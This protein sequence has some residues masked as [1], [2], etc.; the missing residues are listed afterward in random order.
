MALESV[1]MLNV[2]CLNNK[3]IGGDRKVFNDLANGAKD[4]LNIIKDNPDIVFQLSLF[5]SDIIKRILNKEQLTEIKTI[6]QDN[7]LNFLSAFDYYQSMDIPSIP[8]LND[9]CSYAVRYLGFSEFLNPWFEKLFD[10]C[11]KCPEYMRT[12]IVYNFIVKYLV[13]TGSAKLGI[14]CPVSII[15]DFRYDQKLKDIFASGSYNYSLNTININKDLINLRQE[16]D[17]SKLGY[18]VHVVFH[19]LKHAKQWYE[20][21]KGSVSNEIYD[22]IRRLLFDTYLMNGNGYTEYRNNYYYDEIEIGANLA[23]WSNTYRF[24]R[25][26]DLLTKNSKN[27]ILNRIRNQRLKNLIRVKKVDD[28][29]YIPA[30]IYNIDHLNAILDLHS[31]EIRNYPLLKWFYHRS[32]TPR[33]FYDLLESEKHCFK[34]NPNSALKSVFADYYNYVLQQP[35]DIKELMFKPTDI[36]R[37]SIAKIFDIIL[38]DLKKLRDAILLYSPVCESYE[39]A[40]DCIALWRANNVHR[41][42]SII[43][44]YYDYAKYDERL[45]K[46]VLDFFQPKFKNIKKVLKEIKLFFSKKSE[47]PNP[48]VVTDVKK[49]LKLKIDIGY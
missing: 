19:E 42:Y 28:G 12:E 8:M 36:Q 38:I 43:Q 45:Q 48:L 37:Q 24:L 18:I 49:L 1:S 14:P 35:F 41:L 16:S 10:D 3:I 22:Y 30:S 47:L 11:L 25:E 4:I 26:K 34:N 40:I 31:I 44:D 13:K 7:L 15:T 6:L 29:Y 32:G 46:E 27:A 20:A 23:S 39:D 5:E 21:E 2:M 17:T 33:D 9:L